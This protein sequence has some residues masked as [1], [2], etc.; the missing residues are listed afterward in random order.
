M[1]TEAQWQVD[2]SLGPVERLERFIAFCRDELNVFGPV[3]WES[4]K[5]DVSDTIS[6][7]GRHCTVSLRFHSL[8][9]TSN[10]NDGPPM[11]LQIRDFSKAFLR[12]RYG[13]SPT[14]NVVGY[15]MYAMR[16]L[17]RA[18]IEEGCESICELNGAVFDSAARIAM[19]EWETTA[20][21]T[22]A[23]LQKIAEFL[24]QENL[25]VSPLKWVSP[26]P[27][28]RSLS[29][30]T[31][32]EAQRRRE[33]NLPD[34]R[35]LQVLAEVFHS[36]LDEI[37]VLAAS[38]GALLAA[39][40]SR[41]NE[42]VSLAADAEVKREYEGKREYGWRWSGSKGAAP[43][44]KWLIPTMAEIGE[45][46]FAKIRRITDEARRMALWYEEHPGQM[47]LPP[48]MAHLR[49]VENIDLKDVEELL[50]Y[51]D[52]GGTRLL[53]ELKIPFIL[54]NRENS[55]SPGQRSTVR[56]EDLEKAVL[57]QLPRG[58]PVRDKRDGLRFSESLFVV[59]LKFFRR[60]RRSR[61]MFE[62]VQ[63]DHIVQ[64]F[65]SPRKKKAESNSIFS[66]RD[67]R[68]ENG[69]YLQ[70]RSHQ[71][72]HWLN[73]LAREGGL[74]E[75]E[76]ARW[77]GRRDVRQNAAYDHLTASQM[78]EMV[79]QC[80]G[81]DAQPLPEVRVNPPVRRGQIAVA[82]FPTAHETE[83]GICVHDWVISPCSKH[84]DCL[85]CGEQY[86]IKGDEVRN[87]RIRMQLEQANQR[88]EAAQA[89]LAD[90]TAGADRWLEHYQ[91]TVDRLRGLVSLLDDPRLPMGSV[92][93]LQNAQEHSPLG[94]AVQDYLATS[95]F[96]M[97]Q[98]IKSS[99]G[100]SGLYGVACIRHDGGAGKA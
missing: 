2:E 92:I 61:V 86:C 18:M 85:N 90:R 87:A 26:I 67:M 21:Q 91:L 80:T 48:D 30:R 59:P 8:S 7:P 70:I 25:T 9:E 15:A 37:D 34:E 16:A 32:P 42:I 39:A 51:H 13:Q 78:L 96:D 79:K 60:T 6:Y 77:S 52:G 57:K 33:Q 20:H 35:A 69:E 53:H 93:W 11:G 50:G 4:N 66:R 27:S 28:R 19:G 43:A 29:D 38:A 22:G 62:P 12:Y 55:W 81:A 17:E 97:Q 1:T 44:I 75:V 54:G 88:L 99:P 64:Q 74:S 98:V 14:R 47:Y 63:L 45:L 40:P 49:G 65:G 71:L 5:W 84:R 41:I 10:W 58:F 24:S 3:D 36:G 82:D 94:V 56:F 68:G 100:P 83:F 73:N 89:A 31:G 95:G 76:L 72:R 46:A 23:W